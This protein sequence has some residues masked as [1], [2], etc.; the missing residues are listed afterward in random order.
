M[1]LQH[2]GPNLAKC[3]KNHTLGVIMVTQEQVSFTV[4]TITPSAN[5]LTG[6]R[7]IGI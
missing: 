2:T 3:S 5:A 7:L 4:N 6:S 1:V